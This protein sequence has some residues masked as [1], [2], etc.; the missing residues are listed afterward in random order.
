MSELH[1]IG[2]HLRLPLVPLSEG[3]HQRLKTYMSK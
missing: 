3:M 1:L 2:N